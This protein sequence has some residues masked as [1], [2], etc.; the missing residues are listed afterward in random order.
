MKRFNFAVAAVWATLLV[1]PVQAVI[2]DSDILEPAEED[3]VVYL[4]EFSKFKQSILTGGSALWREMGL[5][6]LE[7]DQGLHVEM[8]EELVDRYGIDQPI[9]SGAA[10]S[11]LLFTE[12]VRPLWTN[13]GSWM[14]DHDEYCSNGAFFEEMNIRDLRAAIQQTDEQLLVDT[15]SQI[16]EDVYVHLLILVHQMHDDPYDYDSQLLSQDAVDAVLSDAIVLAA[17]GFEI[18]AALNDTW[19]DPAMEGQGFTISV[20]EEKGTVFLAWF[21]YD[22]VLPPQGVVAD[23]GYAGQRWFTAQGS[24]EANSANLVVYS[25]RSGLFDGSLPAPALFPVGTIELQ[26][27]NC[28]SG[29]VSYDLPGSFRAGVIPIERVAS[30]NVA[31]CEAMAKPQF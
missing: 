15:Y 29:T 11:Y 27:E 24:Y 19:Y 23:L 26:F 21:T 30:D 10:F 13:W 2:A 28:N 20:F 7:A 22:T 12:Q 17:D 25:P 3:T 18:N 1:L 31:N 5:E 6:R 14:F 4:L 8:L 9:G 16:L